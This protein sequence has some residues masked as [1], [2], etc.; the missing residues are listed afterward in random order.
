MKIKNYP[1]LFLNQKN[2][3]DRFYTEDSIKNQNGKRVPLVSSFEE[4]ATT[5]G[6][7]DLV[8]TEDKLLANITVT[9]ENLIALLKTEEGKKTIG[10]NTVGMATILNE[11]TIAYVEDLKIVSI[12]KKDSAFSQHH[13]IEL[14]VDLLSWL[15]DV[16][17]RVDAMLDKM[18]DLT[19]EEMDEL[20]KL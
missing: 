17:Q 8:L 16:K 3:N 7:A 18:D 13:D 5:L 1:V 6:V 9:D 14:D 20:R 15:E 12:L 4:D 11:K 2:L 19:K 10:F